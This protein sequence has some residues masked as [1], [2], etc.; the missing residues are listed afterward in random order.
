[1]ENLAKNGWFGG[2]ISGTFHLK[3]TCKPSFWMNDLFGLRKPKNWIVC[4]VK[5]TNWR[6]LKRR[7]K[8]RR[9]VAGRWPDEV[10]TEHLLASIGIYWL[11]IYIYTYIFYIVYIYI[12][13]CIHVYI[14]IDTYWGSSTTWSAGDYVSHQSG[15]SIN[16]Q[17]T[18]ARPPWNG[19]LKPN[20]VF[21]M[22]RRRWCLSTEVY[23]VGYIYI[24]IYIY[25]CCTLYI[26]TYI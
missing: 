6:P 5:R 24:F 9:E 16:G 21:G 4:K 15:V 22:W 26:C 13:L 20:N 14:H 23:Q 2:P 7:K 8:R 1:M 12:Q 3:W 19:R 18:A 11:C 25:I 10:L 17:L